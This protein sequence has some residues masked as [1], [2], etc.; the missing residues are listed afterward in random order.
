MVD[1]SKQESGF[2]YTDSFVPVARYTTL[3]IF[4]AIAAVHGLHS[5]PVRCRECVYLCSIA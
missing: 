3:L 1:G 4:L 5:V 2:D